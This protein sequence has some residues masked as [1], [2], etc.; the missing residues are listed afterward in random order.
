M[1][2]QTAITHR[3]PRGFEEGGILGIVVFASGDVLEHY[4]HDLSLSPYLPLCFIA[5]D[6]DVKLVTI[7]QVSRT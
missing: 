2:A 5:I 1:R 7:M 4:W 3:D 6:Y